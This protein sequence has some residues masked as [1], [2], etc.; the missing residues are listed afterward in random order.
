[1]LASGNEYLIKMLG[2]QGSTATPG[3]NE[4]ADYLDGADE[5]L[6]DVSPEEQAEIEKNLAKLGPEY[7]QIAAIPA[8]LPLL[9]SPAGQAALAAG[10]AAVGTLLIQAGI[11][12]SGTDWGAAPGRDTVGGLPGK[13]GTAG[14]RE[15]TPD[16]QAEVE[17]AGNELRDARRALEDLPDDAT[18][19]ERDMAQ[20]RL[21]RATKNRQR[22][23]NK[24]KQENKNRKDQ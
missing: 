21:D 7:A 6:N 17:A 5:L 22:V 24:H 19:S 3:P 9:A 14:G 12:V 1:M 8:A 20:E 13:G 10:A 23:R 16:Q 4:P 11:N 15:L 18:Q 2:Y